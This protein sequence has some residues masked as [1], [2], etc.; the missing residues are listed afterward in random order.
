M[1]TFL[2]IIAGLSLALAASAQT[3]IF[4]NNSSYLVQVS[5]WNPPP[6]SGVMTTNFQAI[7][8]GLYVGFDGAFSNQLTLAG[9]TYNSS[10]LA[11]FF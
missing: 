7:R 11:G 6:T 10:V 4:G 5:R 1:K 2:A 3:V 9:T 8:F